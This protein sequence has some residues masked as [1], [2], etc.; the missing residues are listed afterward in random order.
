MN[1]VQLCN[2]AL[3]RLGGHAV[4]EAL[5][6]PDE[7]AQAC[8]R[9]Y[10]ATAEAALCAYAWPF[11]ERR[12]ELAPL[13]ASPSGEWDYAFALPDDCIKPVRLETAG[14]EFFGRR[15]AYA[16][17][18]K[19]LMC[20]AP[21]AE[22]VYVAFVEPDLWP[23]TFAQYVSWRLAGE[24]ALALDARA[25]L[26]KFALDRASVEELR[27]ITE[28]RSSERPRPAP[29]AD[30]VRSRGGGLACDDELYRASFK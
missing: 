20:D 10:R 9:V 14:G 4:I 17:A 25:D 24:L 26:A 6:A 7:E 19:A 16:V 18:G 8:A 27:A 22:L 15:A 21:S 23:P 29:D 2:L 11:A 13:P 1:A 3:G 5:D 12:A 28:A 30:W